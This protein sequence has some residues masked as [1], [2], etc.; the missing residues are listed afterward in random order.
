MT[1][2][3][4]WLLLSSTSVLAFCSLFFSV[5]IHVVGICDH[6]YALM[7]IFLNYLFCHIIELHSVLATFCAFVLVSTG[8]FNL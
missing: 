6:L 7:I 5:P 2:L 4:Y 1:C 8:R 3:S